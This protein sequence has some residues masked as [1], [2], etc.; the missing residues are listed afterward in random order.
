MQKLYFLQKLV[1]WLRPQS[2]ECQSKALWLCRIFSSSDLI[3]SPQLKTEKAPMPICCKEQF[4]IGALLSF[5]VFVPAKILLFRQV[6]SF[7]NVEIIL[8]LI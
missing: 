7:Q 6:I 1:G 8:D 2:P 3:E 4:D 5:L